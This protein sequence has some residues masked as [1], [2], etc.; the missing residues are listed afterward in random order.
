LDTGKY[1]SKISGKILFAYSDPGGAKPILAL[2]ESV[3]N[4]QIKIISDRSYSFESDF[5]V[6]VELINEAILNEVIE[7]FS[8]S[9]V[10]TGTS[11][12][13]S[14]DRSCLLIAERLQIHC[15]SF[16]DHYTRFNDRFLLS[17]DQYVLPN[18]LW[19]LD[20]QA[21]KI[22]KESILS[23]TPIRKIGNPYRDWLKKWKPKVN[24]A[25]FLKEFHLPEPKKKIIL[26]AP[27]PLSNIDGKNKYGFDEIDVLEELITNLE[28]NKK[29]RDC[30]T[31]W[32]KPHPNQN[33]EVLKA[34][35]D[36]TDLITLIPIE[37]NTNLCLYFCDVVFGFFSSVLLEA[38]ILNKKV[39]RYFPL[40][41]Q[42]PFAHLGGME[43]LNK[44]TIS[45]L[46]TYKVENE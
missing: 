17:N 9:L 8:P 36:K 13:A 28:S 37:A 44:A 22:A 26:F 6:D 14:F 27:D 39:F 4:H 7:N 25:S 18:E 23:E 33:L 46:F 40:D 29:Y 3:K 1:F 34:I 2:A 30:F 41:R 35:F 31:I 11:F 15:V 19:V 20:E 10:V 16:V 38:E 5:H 45:Q 24:I 12:P 42:D 43:K 32:F 21:E